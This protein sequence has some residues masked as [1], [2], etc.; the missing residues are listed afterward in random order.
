MIGIYA[1]RNKVNGHL[2]IGQ[3]VDIERR[4]SGHKSEFRKGTHGN[5]HLSSAFAKYG[6]DSFELI[7]LEQTDVE[8]LDEREIYWI[9]HYGGCDSD[10]LYNM[11]PGG[12]GIGRSE[13]KLT[14]EERENRSKA[15]CRYNMRKQKEWYGLKKSPKVCKVCGGNFWGHDKRVRCSD[16]I[17]AQRKIS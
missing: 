8:H 12:Q 6:E 5:A 13:K 1:I 10:T 14:P 7:I 15:I 3:S 17:N 2:Y 11:K 9:G 4:W 16:Y